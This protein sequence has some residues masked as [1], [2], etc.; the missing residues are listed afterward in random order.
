VIGK[1][2]ALVIIEG[3]NM[4][5]IFMGDTPDEPV[6]PKLEKE[7]AYVLGHEMDQQQAAVMLLRHNQG[8]SD[9]QIGRLIG[10]RKQEVQDL[11]RAGSRFL[12]QRFSPY[13]QT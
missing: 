4:N 2:H 3:G 5:E 1:I 6:D 8:M 13:N 7:L 9:R 10:L 11:G 12:Y